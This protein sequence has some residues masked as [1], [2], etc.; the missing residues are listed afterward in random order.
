MPL[1][2]LNDVG[3][4]IGLLIKKRFYE[5]RHVWSSWLREKHI[6]ENEYV[7]AQPLKFLRSSSQWPATGFKSAGFTLGLIY[8]KVT[9]RK[10]CQTAAVTW[11]VTGQTRGRVL[12]RSRGVGWQASLMTTSRG[13]QRT[14]QPCRW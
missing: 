4:G 1:G 3:D 10:L 2:L 11:W 13:R 14:K 9:W 5:G 6:T 7:Q 8:L 12:S